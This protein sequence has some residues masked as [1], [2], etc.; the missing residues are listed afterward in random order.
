MSPVLLEHEAL[1]FSSKQH[2]MMLLG[3]EGGCCTSHC[4][5]LLPAW[6]QR[7]VGCGFPTA[8]ASVSG[9]AVLSI[10]LTLNV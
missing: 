5:E 10:S 9:A 2:S 7:G 3:Q 4:W 1:P 8:G 6:G